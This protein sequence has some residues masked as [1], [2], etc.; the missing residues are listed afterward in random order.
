LHGKPAGLRTHALVSLG[1]AAA[2]IIVLE[3]PNGLLVADQNAIGRLQ[4]TANRIV[5]AGGEKRQ[6]TLAGAKNQT[7]IDACAAFK[8]V[9]AKTANA[10]PGMKMRFPKAFQD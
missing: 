1:A 2:T 8:I 7:E 3:S 4:Q 5:I 9:I 10:H 6:A